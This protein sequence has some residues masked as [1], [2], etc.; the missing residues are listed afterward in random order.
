MLDSI[1]NGGNTIERSEQLNEVEGE[2]V[3]R[4]RTQ[5]WF[6]QIRKTL[7]LAMTS[8]REKNPLSISCQV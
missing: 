8:T 4:V 7:T 2:R 6:N 3:I 5:K 1:T